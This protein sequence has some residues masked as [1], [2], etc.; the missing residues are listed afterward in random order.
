MR[1]SGSD[2]PELNQPSGI[3]ARDRLRALVQGRTVRLVHRYFDARGRILGKVYLEQTWVNEVLIQEGLAWF[4]DPDHDCPDLEATARAA[5]A[6]RRGLW[7]SSSPIP[8][9]EWRRGARW[10]KAGMEES[11]PPPPLRRSPSSNERA[12]LG[13]P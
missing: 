12:L 13:F 2:A 5:K 6:S 1:L 3:L 7:Q 8:P 11:Q 9:W 10:F 4:G